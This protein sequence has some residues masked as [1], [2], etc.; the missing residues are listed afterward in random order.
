MKVKF[1]KFA[2]SCHYHTSDIANIAMTIPYIAKTKNGHT[3]DAIVAT[4]DA[5]I[6]THMTR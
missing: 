4:H 3:H 2:H 5:I 6:T 1:G